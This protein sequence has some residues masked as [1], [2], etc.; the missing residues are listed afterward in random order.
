MNDL[1]LFYYVKFNAHISVNFLVLWV[2]FCLQ[3]NGL[4]TQVIVL[5]VLLPWRYYEMPNSTS[6]LLPP[7]VL[8]D[9]SLCNVLGSG[10]RLD[11]YAVRLSFNTNIG[12]QWWGHVRDDYLRRVRAS[13]IQNVDHNL[14]MHNGW[15]LT[16]LHL[17]LS[18]LIGTSK[19]QELIF[20]S[21]EESA[22]QPAQSA[23][24]YCLQI[25]S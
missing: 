1:M 8:Y 3:S 10:M 13:A 24:I 21:K 23:P 15:D 6:F 7:T 11:T 19:W 18:W 25:S 9:C 22:Y 17:Q 20:G 14:S 12:L 4:P 16:S 2:Q 5:N